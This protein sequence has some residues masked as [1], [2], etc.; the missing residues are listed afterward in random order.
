MLTSIKG[1][2]IIGCKGKFWV[3]VSKSVV[4]AMV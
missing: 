2:S 3:V 1:Q 4:A